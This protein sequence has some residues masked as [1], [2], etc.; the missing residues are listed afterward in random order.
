[1]I[2]TLW[3]IPASMLGAA[4]GIFTIALCVAKGRGDDNDRS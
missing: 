3:L 2:H 1:M 4:V